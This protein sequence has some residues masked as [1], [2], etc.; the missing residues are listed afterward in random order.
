MA[1][2]FKSLITNMVDKTIDP[3][4]DLQTK[5]QNQA[6]V[7]ESARKVSENIKKSKG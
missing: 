5:I 2:Q 6:K 4:K 7:N 1:K 3:M